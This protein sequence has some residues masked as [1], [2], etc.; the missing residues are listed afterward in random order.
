MELALDILKWSGVAAVAL[1]V[2]G[3]L[4]VA[5]MAWL[6]NHPVDEDGEEGVGRC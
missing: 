4:V 3:M 1:A 5:V 2:A 6:L